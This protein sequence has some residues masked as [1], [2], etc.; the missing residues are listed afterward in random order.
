MGAG[1]LKTA[2]MTAK[3]VAAAIG[4]PFGIDSEKQTWSWAN[5][6]DAWVNHP[7]ESFAAVFPFGASFLKRKGITPSELQV[8]ELVDSAV[9][10]EKTPLAQEL[11]IEMEQGPPKQDLD[12]SEDSADAQKS[13]ASFGLSEAEAPTAYSVAFETK[14]HPS[15]A[16]TRA[17]HFRAANDALLSAMEASP[18]LAERMSQL[19]IEVPRTASGAAKGV[20]PNGWTWHHTEEPGVMQLVPRDQHAAGNPFRETMH[21]NGRGGFA[22]WGTD[23]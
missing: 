9:K 22:I 3:G 4:R 10:N 19:G 14:I 15:G 23:F 6:K 13:G 8:K 5:F 11:K 2:E 21:P 18:E 7:V 1:A 16:G 17:A 12:F 20:S